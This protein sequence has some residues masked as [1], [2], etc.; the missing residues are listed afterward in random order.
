MGT[1]REKL[2]AGILGEG[3]DRRA[4]FGNLIFSQL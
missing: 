2:G 3:T 4:R 1:T